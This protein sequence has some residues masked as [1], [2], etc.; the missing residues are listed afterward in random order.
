V[1]P[2]NTFRLNINDNRIGEYHRANGLTKLLLSEE[3][4]LPYLRVSE[5]LIEL[6]DLVAKSLL[7][8][9]KNFLLTSSLA[10][11]P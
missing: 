1:Q 5:G 6:E 7:L 8:K 10:Y 4:S 11:M 9:R 2:N 3:F